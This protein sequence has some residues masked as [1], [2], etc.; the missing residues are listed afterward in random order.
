[1]SIYKYFSF[2]SFDVALGVTI[3]HMLISQM[4]E[5]KVDIVSLYCLFCTVLWIYSCDHI[6]DVIGKKFRIS[7]KYIFYQKHF[8]VLLFFSG[9]SLLMTV[10][11]I[12]FLPLEI[13]YRGI[14]LSAFILCYFLITQ[15]KRDT[16]RTIYKEH[17][18]ALG[19]VLGIFLPVYNL[20][21]LLSLEVTY[22]FIHCYILAF[23]SILLFS[24]IDYQNDVKDSQVSMAT[25]LGYSKTLRQFYFFLVFIVLCDV[26]GGLLFSWHWWVLCFGT[27]TVIFL[28]YHY[29]I[30]LART[31]L[32]RYCIEANLFAFP[33]VY[34]YAMQ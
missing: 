21:D 31:L 22:L 16:F 1:M 32:Y 10:I 19:Y 15:Y 28:I 2:F 6:I 3:Q 4:L 30:P 8:S 14:F 26:L 23:L 5:E 33:I 25:L 7:E 13:I 9:S 20:F 17:W 34:L 27:N 12:W 24:L 18:I 11:G 29:R